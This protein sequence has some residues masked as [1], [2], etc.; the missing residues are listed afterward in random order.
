MS[1]QAGNRLFRE[2]LLA[3]AAHLAAGAILA[4]P[5]L[6]LSRR[7]HFSRRGALLILALSLVAFTL[8]NWRRFRLRLQRLRVLR[9]ISSSR[10]GDHFITLAST[11]VHHRTPSAKLL[12]QLHEVAS[13]RKYPNTRILQ[14]LES[15]A[16]S[17]V[18]TRSSP[19][20]LGRFL[21]LL[22]SAKALTRQE[23]VQHLATFLTRLS[24]D[25]HLVLYGY[26]STICDTLTSV[27]SSLRIPIF[28]VED[29]QYGAS[30]SLAEHLRAEKH[31]RSGGLEPFIVPFAEVA[32]LCSPS[33]DFV[34]TVDH[35]AIPLASR[36]RMLALIG[37]EAV[38]VRGQVLIPSRLKGQPSETAKFVEVFQA[39]ASRQPVQTPFSQIVVVAESYKVYPLLS[40]QLCV[41]R[42][43][44]RRSPFRS[45]LYL[46]G[47]GRL[48]RSLE[49]ELVVLSPVDVAAIIDDCGHHAP[50]GD[51]I[52]MA[53]SLAA[54]EQRTVCHVVP[55]Y[56]PDVSDALRRAR[57]VIFDFN[58]VLLDDEPVHFSAF[59]DVVR[60]QGGNL[61]FAEYL[62]ECSGRTDSEGIK[63]LQV[64]GIIAGATSELLAL[65]RERYRN[66]AKASTPA[67]FA[68]AAELLACLRAAGKTT[69]IV[70]SAP[71]DSVDAFFAAYAPDAVVPAENVYSEIDAARRRE[72]YASILQRSN[73]RAS[74]CVL[75][76]DSPRNVRE[77]R[78]LGFPTIAV[79]TTH[80]TSQFEA[81]SIARNIQEILAAYRVA[82]VESNPHLRSA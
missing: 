54:W 41:S 65:K 38:D 37:C 21:S 80:D 68:G 14:S 23:V 61:T 78:D 71:R 64:H 59:S 19:E 60:L 53:R 50:S 11:L 74:E 69:F 46:I 31:L 2:F 3:L 12:A 77:A 4:A 51:N 45:F 18:G 52:D 5:V 15:L 56:S 73:I 17:T 48:P 9:E 22:P 72:T 66:Y 24:A 6:A 82:S 25:T 28:L 47:A 36:R 42:S 8:I 75:I 43:P 13:L 26:S 20:L 16:A 63:N 44:L 32:R 62:T 39:A 7:L 67:A 55:T 58:G 76:D 27:A 40:G 34:N 79:T 49:V 33:A 10:C 30:G 70:T 29:L 81:D 35:R 1:A 57:T